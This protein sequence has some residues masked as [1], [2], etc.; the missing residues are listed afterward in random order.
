M[1][2]SG[3]KNI[4]ATKNRPWWLL[5][6]EGI[7]A[8]I[9]GGILI[10]APSTTQQNTWIILVIV[11]GLYWLVSGIL[12]L[13]RLF[14]NQKQWGLK[15]F[16]GIL[17]ILAGGYILVYPAISAAALPS[18]IL[19]VLGILGCMHGLTR[20]VSAFSGAGWGAGIMGV[21]MIILGII[22]IVNFANP[23]YGIALLYGAAAAIFIM[24]FVLLFKSFRHQ[25]TE[26]L[27]LY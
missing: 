10:W 24:G 15:L 14:Q 6:M 4:D 17:S 12:S 20:L 25:P 13:A 23:A 2:N 1:V 3:N 27:Y 11:L 5:F 7:F 16:T 21:L 9:L 18:I 26:N 8:I 19:L 22:L